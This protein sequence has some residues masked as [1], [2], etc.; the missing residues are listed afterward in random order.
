MFASLISK[1][2][3]LGT[4]VRYHLM[5]MSL[6][7][8]AFAFGVKY[9]NSLL[10][11]VSWNFSLYF[12]LEILWFQLQFLVF[13]YLQLV[14]LLDGSIYCIVTFFV[15]CYSFLL[16]IYFDIL[17]SFA[18]SMLFPLFIFSLVTLNPKQVFCRHHIFVFIY[19]FNSFSHSVPFDWGI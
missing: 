6:T 18:W 15:S 9:K 2:M 17:V 10:R 5:L 7:F 14:Y 11:S 19:L 3:E 16:N 13:Q 12:L 8:V 1:R 4:T